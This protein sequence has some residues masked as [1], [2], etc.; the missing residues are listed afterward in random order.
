[1]VLF[2]KLVKKFVINPVPAPGSEKSNLPATRQV[3][4][5]TSYGNQNATAPLAKRPSRFDKEEKVDPAQLTAQ[6][7]RIKQ[8]Q[9]KVQERIA[10]VE[11]GFNFCTILHLKNHFQFYSAS[12]I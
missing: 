8:R 7:L 6:Q 10:T 12:Q 11:L 4:S 5:E 9:Q 1:M 3:V 2:E